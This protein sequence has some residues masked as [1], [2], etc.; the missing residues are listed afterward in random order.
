MP[1]RR[2]ARAAAV[3][4]RATSALS[5]LPLSVVLHI[6]SLLPVDSRLRCAEVCRGWRAVLLERSLWTRL[7]LTRASGVHVRVHPRHVCEVVLRHAAARAGGGLRSLHIDKS[8]VTH[9]ALLEVAAANAGALRE[10][11]THTPSLIGFSTLVDASALLGA[12][13]LLDVLATDL[14]CYPADLPAARRALRNEAPFGPLRV[15]RLRAF[16]DAGDEARFIAFAADVAAHASL[17]ELSIRRAPLGNA[18]ALDA[19]VDAAL[20]RRMDSVTLDSC[21][22]SPAS[23]PALARLLG[24]GALTALECEGMYLLDAPAAAVLAAALRGNSTLTSLTLDDVGVFDDPAAAA[25]LLGALTSHVSVQ[26][27]SVTCNG[28]IVTAAHRAAVGAAL[29]TLV[30]ANAPALTHLDVSYCTLGDDGLRALFE[31]LPRNTHLCALH[32]CNNIMSELFLRD[33][34][35]PAVRANTSLRKLVAY[36]RG[37]GGASAAEA[38]RIM[39]S[40]AAA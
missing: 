28:V 11:R 1:P 36:A 17:S 26:T 13:P 19:V 3:A 24:G 14:V 9:A 10:L 15:R 31:A 37:G 8:F 4:E 7:D 30:A 35:L 27:L 21:G 32:C 5:P 22:L 38:E 16:F 23:A 33:A 2:S 6:F 12:A 18:D 39:R 29:G 40:R 20:A 25:E 34:L